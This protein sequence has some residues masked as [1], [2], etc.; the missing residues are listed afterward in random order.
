MTTEQFGI[1]ARVTHAGASGDIRHICGT[2]IAVEGGKRRIRLDDGMIVTWEVE[3]L[4]SISHVR[5][6][7]SDVVRGKT[8]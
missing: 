1:D 2:V 6:K 7:K 3:H 4:R 8:R 5:S